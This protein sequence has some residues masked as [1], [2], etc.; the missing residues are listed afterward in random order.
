MNHGCN[1][2][3]PRLGDQGLE[4]TMKIEIAIAARGCL[5]YDTEIDAETNAYLDA[6]ADAVAEAV[7]DAYP[8]ASVECDIDWS[9]PATKIS[10]DGDLDIDAA[11]ETVRAILQHLWG[12]PDKWWHRNS[13]FHP[14]A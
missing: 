11:D 10:I 13:E 12:N 3:H 2:R 1:E 5:D 6:Y 9:T 8:D 7:A 4:R 14:N